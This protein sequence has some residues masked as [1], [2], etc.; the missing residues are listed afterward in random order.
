MTNLTHLTITEA[1]RRLAKGEITAVE[2]TRAHTEAMA[3]KRG[4]N[5][6]ITE[7][8]DLALEQAAL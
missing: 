5:A 3:A 8:P 6:F 1:R 2:L 7:T 4:L